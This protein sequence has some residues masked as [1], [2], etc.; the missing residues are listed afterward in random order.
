MGL[1]ALLSLLATSLIN[2][3]STFP[4]VRQYIVETFYKSLE[5]A[6]ALAAMVILVVSFLKFT[7]K[8]LASHAKRTDEFI[9]TVKG[10]NEDSAKLV[11][12]TNDLAVKN[13]E[14]LVTNTEATRQVT[15]CFTDFAS[16]LAQQNQ[17]RKQH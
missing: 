6:P 13:I 3:R 1:A 4:Y 15:K 10:M 12:R 14:A 2:G 17:H 8:L 11:T 7:E 5:H 16:G 9:F